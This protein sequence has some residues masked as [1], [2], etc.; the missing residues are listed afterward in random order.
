MSL[1]YSNGPQLG[2]EGRVSR[3]SGLH[4]EAGDGPFHVHTPS[5]PG[6]GPFCG[7]SV[8][9][10]LQLRI[11][12]IAC[13]WGSGLYLMAMLGQKGGGESPLIVSFSAGVAKRAVGQENL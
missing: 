9:P 6:L 2:D 3:A 8:R 12:A 5:S 13:C 11:I 10:F 4:G 7:G 1:A